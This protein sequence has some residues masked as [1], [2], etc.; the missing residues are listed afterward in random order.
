MCRWKLN[1]GNLSSIILLNRTGVLSGDCYVKY[2]DYELTSPKAFSVCSGL[3]AQLPVPT[4]DSENE[5]L[6][7]NFGETFLGIRGELTD[8]VVTW[9]DIY[10]KVKFVIRRLRP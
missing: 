6:T 1:I 3:N 9:K 2:K 8:D 10:T 4:S 7:K 5:F